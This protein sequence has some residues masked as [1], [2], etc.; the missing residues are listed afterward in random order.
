MG[1]SKI[2]G[3]CK[4]G[5]RSSTYNFVDQVLGMDKVIF[6]VD[7]K[8]VAAGINHS[9]EDVRM[10]LSLLVRLK[11]AENYRMPVVKTPLS[12]LLAGKLMWLFILLYG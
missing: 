4:G 12:S 2:T 1:I 6:E 9:K 11:S 8:H 5:C 7:S 10:L 3:S